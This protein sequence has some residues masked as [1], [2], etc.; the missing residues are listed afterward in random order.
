MHIPLN[1]LEVIVC[2]YTVTTQTQTQTQTDTDT[3][4]RPANSFTNT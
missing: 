2:Q 3:D 1:S 4:T